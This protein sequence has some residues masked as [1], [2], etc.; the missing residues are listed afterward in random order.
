MARKATDKP[1]NLSTFW[2]PL[3]LYKMRAASVWGGSCLLCAAPT[4]LQA[5]FCQACEGDMAPRGRLAVSQTIDFVSKTF[6]AFEYGFPLDYLVKRAKFQRDWCAM[7]ALADRFARRMGDELPRFDVAVP[8]PLGTA[9]F[10]A[11]GFNQ[12]RVLADALAPDAVAV[13]LSKR[14]GRVQSLLGRAA[15]RANVEDRYTATAEVRG[16]TVLLVDDIV[17]TG[18][19]LAACGQALRSAGARQVYA[20]VLA[21]TPRGGGGAVE[22]G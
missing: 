17:T 5:G 11:R 4:G 3:H 16:A 15:R 2:R 19:T 8:V 12:A 20:A 7:V 14:G 18:S 21:H 9:R 13:C 1:G 6:A 10:V 22:T